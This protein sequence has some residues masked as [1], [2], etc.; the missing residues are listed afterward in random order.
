[1]AQFTGWWN[2]VAVADIDGDGR[3]DIVASNWGLNT[4]YRATPKS[5]ERIYFGDLLESGAI[6]LIEA[7]YDSDPSRIV[8][9]RPIDVLGAAIPPLRERY[10]SHRA[11]GQATID[12]AFGPY[13]SRMREMEVTTL[14]ST[15]FLNRGGKFDAVELPA[16]AQWAPAFAVCVGDFDGDGLD[17]IFLS[18][19][20]FDTQ[21]ELSRCDAG[22]GLWLR[23]LGGGKLKAVSGQESGI[24]VYGEQRGAAVCD[25]NHDGRVD[26]VV[27][28]NSGETKLYT[29]SRAKVGLRVRL[30]GRA[31]NPDAIGAQLRVRYRGGKSGPVRNI[32]AGSGYWSQ[33]SSTQVLGLADVPEAVWVRWPSG[34][35]QTVSVEPNAK[36]IRVEFKP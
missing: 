27:T 17:D 25:F 15:V 28:Q 2:G 23:N 6:D 5:P 18:Q 26:L 9:T 12:E 19:N 3:L 29:N 20:F 33:D 16:E 32:A 30:Q 14:A 21:M 10:T 35:E 1:L 7:E 11:F 24:E 4:G 22:R 31:G 34:K 13:K 36:E 8:P